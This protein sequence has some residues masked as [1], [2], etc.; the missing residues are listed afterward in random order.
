MVPK[1]FN[2][3]PSCDKSKLDELL[4]ITFEEVYPQY[5]DRLTDTIAAKVYFAY[6][7]KILEAVKEDKKYFS[8]KFLPIIESDSYDFQKYVNKYVKSQVN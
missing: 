2:E 3:I 5:S 4:K 6:K 7:D 1:V 8:T